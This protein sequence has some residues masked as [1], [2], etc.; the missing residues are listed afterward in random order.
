VLSG[1]GLFFGLAV[2]DLGPVVSDHAADGSAGNRMMTR[3]MA[4]YRAHGRPL[5]TAL[6][7]DEAR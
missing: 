6:G 3:H 2:L 4:G 5:H 1:G 7:L